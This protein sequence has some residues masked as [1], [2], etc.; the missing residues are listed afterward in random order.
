METRDFKVNV[1]LPPVGL[2]S[3]EEDYFAWSGNKADLQ[4]EYF[5]H[6]LAHRL[7]PLRQP[8]CFCCLRMR[9]VVVREWPW[10]SDLSVV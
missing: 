8:D 6:L 9:Q 7:P 2:L 1:Q 4:S 3:L 5:R 10:F